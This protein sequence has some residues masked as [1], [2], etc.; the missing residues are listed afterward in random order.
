MYLTLIFVWGERNG[1]NFIR[2]CGNPFSSGPFV[3]EVILFPLYVLHLSNIRWLQLSGFILGPLFYFTSIC[4]FL[5]QYLLFYHSG[6][7]E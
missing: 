6:S 7:V 1:F 5:Y 4:L 2:V 3:E